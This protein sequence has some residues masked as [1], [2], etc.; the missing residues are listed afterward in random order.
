MRQKLKT[1]MMESTG[2]KHV[3]TILIFQRTHVGILHPFDVIVSTRSVAFEEP[4]TCC[5]PEGE[6]LLRRNSGFEAVR[7]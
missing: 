7:D 6:C 3:D 2:K 1:I 5:P 4:W